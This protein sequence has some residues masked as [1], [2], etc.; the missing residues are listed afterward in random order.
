MTPARLQFRSPANILAIAFSNQRKEDR[1]FVK[2]G[3][4]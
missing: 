3:I 1:I 2:P 4:E